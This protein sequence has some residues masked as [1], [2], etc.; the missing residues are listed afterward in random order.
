MEGRSTNTECVITVE[1]IRR[2]GSSPPEVQ[3]AWG[4]FYNL[5]ACAALTSALFA[6]FDALR[7]ILEVIHIGGFSWIVVPRGYPAVKAPTA[8]IS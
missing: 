6:R 8:L 5:N 4:A 7:R 3:A 1:P 2:M